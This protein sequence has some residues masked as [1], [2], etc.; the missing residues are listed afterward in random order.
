MAQDRRQGIRDIHR[1]STDQSGIRSVDR[2]ATCVSYIHAQLNRSPFADWKTDAFDTWVRPCLV[3][4]PE[5]D[6]IRIAVPNNYRAEWLDVVFGGIV[7]EAISKCL[8]KNLDI[9][10]VDSGLNKDEVTR[11]A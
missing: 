11:D 8:G 4:A 7:S 6:R 1:G 9:E 5:D 2:W 10:Y 3:G